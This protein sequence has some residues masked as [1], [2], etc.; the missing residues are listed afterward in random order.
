MSD[1]ER[2]E[3]Q[4]KPL[5]GWRIDNRTIVPEFLD[6]LAKNLPKQ[7]GM[8]PRLYASCFVINCE[9]GRNGQSLDKLQVFYDAYVAEQGQKAAA[10][11]Q[12]APQVSDVLHARAVE[13]GYDPNSPEM[14]AARNR[15]REQLKKKG[16]A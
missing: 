16:L 8:A 15:V 6:F 11:A 5:P 7:D 3:R 13:P 1:I 4:F 2:F 10:A 9:T 14:I 12:P